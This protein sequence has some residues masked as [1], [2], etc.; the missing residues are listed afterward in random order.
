MNEADS[1]AECAAVDSSARYEVYLRDEV[2]L[3]ETELGPVH[4]DLAESLYRLAVHVRY[5]GGVAEADSLFRRALSIR[6]T[7]YGTEHPLVAQVLEGL[8]TSL[9][10]QGRLEES[11]TVLRRAMDIRALTGKMTWEYSSVLEKRAVLESAR[12]ELEKADATFREAIGIAEIVCGADSWGLVE[13]QWHYGMMLEIHKLY[14]RTLEIGD[15]IRAFAKKQVFED[16]SA[17]DFLAMRARALHMLGLQSEWQEAIEEIKTLK[18][19]TGDSFGFSATWV[20]GCDTA[21]ITN[22][23]SQ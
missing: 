11:G 8:S 23:D 17:F 7:V 5:Q 16:C 3:R 10:F 15:N 9:R 4:P 20:T 12:G 1:N 13:T 2:A 21:I 19:Q 18:A 6:E 22:S 14:E